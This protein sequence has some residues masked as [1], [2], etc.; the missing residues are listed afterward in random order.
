M[1]GLPHFGR[2]PHELPRAP[3]SGPPE[4]TSVS[5]ELPSCPASD[6]AC[7]GHTLFISKQCLMTPHQILLAIKESLMPPVNHCSSE[8]SVGRGGKVPE[9]SNCISLYR[10]CF[11]CYSLQ[12]RPSAIRIKIALR[13]KLRYS[14][15]ISSY[16]ELNPS[17]SPFRLGDSPRNAELV[18]RAL[19]AGE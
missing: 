2:T 15:Y 7:L 14:V 13:V 1:P 16:K 8:T 3:R 19:I 9:T 5:Q 18:W 4:C 17:K 12:S 11:Q 10:N 6:S